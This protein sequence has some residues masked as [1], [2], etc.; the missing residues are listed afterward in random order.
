[1]I[2]PDKLTGT[3]LDDADAGN[4]ARERDSLFLLTEISLD[5]DSQTYK[6]RVRNLSEGGMMVECDMH[7]AKDQGLSADLRN[8][9]NVRG[10]IAWAKPGRF[11]IA[12]DTPIDP[13]LA[14]K[15]VTGGQHEP[16]YT[17]TIITGRTYR[18]R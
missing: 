11:G 2:E 9:G 10:R 18:P 17:R 4:R 13:K 14:R 8:I 1:M 6:A 3:P 12:F 5:G 7:A 15:P 16:R